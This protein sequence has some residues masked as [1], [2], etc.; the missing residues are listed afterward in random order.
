MNK[1]EILLVEDSPDDV[2]LAIHALRREKLAN[3][4]TVARDGEEALDF[5]FCRGSYTQRSFQN[6]VRLILLDLKLP[7][8]GGLEVLKAIKHDPRTKA[9]PVVIMTSSREERDMV[10]GYK[11]GVNAY[12]QKPVD[13]E[14]F[15]G[16]VKELG[17]FWLVINQAPPAQAFDAT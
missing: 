14:Q 11:L 7:K 6:P 1:N 4:I 10:D 15:R 13:F 2:E 3:D 9:I 16:V 8:I 5:V 17:L 12:V